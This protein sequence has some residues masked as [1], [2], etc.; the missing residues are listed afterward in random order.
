MRETEDAVFGALQRA[1][2]YFDENDAMLQR[3][4]FTTARKRLDDIVASFSGHA[5]DQ[6]VGDRGARGETAKQKH[7]RVKLRGEQMEPIA[8]I[9]RHNLR[10]APEFRALRKPS[11][12][13]RGHA[14]IASAKGMADAAAIHKDTLVAEGMP[15][16]FLDDFKAAIA[17]LEASMSD[18]E[19]KRTQRV[20]ATKG[21]AVERKNGQTIL[22]VLDA[23]VKQ[24]L[25]ADNEAL[26]RQWQS[27]RLVRRST[28][29]T[30]AA[31]TTP[32][33]AN[34]T[35]QPSSPSGTTTPEG[36]I[37]STST[38]LG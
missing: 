7:L 30:S 16:T 17:E 9:A 8:V 6:N 23:L 29:N 20:G 21:L 34:A 14:F 2:R 19:Q 11:Q 22:S 37:M 32:S 5:L 13:V 12:K 24:A 33:T 25:G 27:A 28:A 10:S 18:R 15:A 35:S 4:D 31:T 1:Q 3:V 26:L 38:R 36:V